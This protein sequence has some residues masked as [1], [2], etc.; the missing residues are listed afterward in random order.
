MQ[1]PDHDDSYSKP[2]TSSEE[3]A[4]GQDIADVRETFARSFGRDA[5]PL[6]EYSEQF[7]Q[8][9]LDPFDYFVEADV[10]NRETVT[11]EETIKCYER[12]FQQWK[13]S[14]EPND[15]HPACPSTRHVKEFIEWRRDTHG[16][17]RRTISGRLN[18][19]SQAYQFWQQDSALPHPEDFNP[20]ELA[21]TVTDI[22]DDEDKEFHNL[23]LEDLQEKFARIEDIKHRAVIGLQLKLG[24]RAGEVSNI[25]LQD[26]HLS[27]TDLKQQY[28]TLG[29]HPALGDHQNVLYVPHNRDGNKSS[30]PRLLPIDEELRWLLIRWL[31]IR[32]SVDDPW[33]FLSERYTQLTAKTVNNI[34]KTEFHPEYSETDDSRAIT[35][36]YGRHWFS[37]Y[38]RLEVG[39]DREHVQYMRGDR[40]Q[41]MNSFG[42]AIDEYLH[43]R[44]EYIEGI[45][46]S[47]SHTLEVHQRYIDTKTH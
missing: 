2:G 29:N 14:M 22:G 30:N 32:P 10:R 31:L 45:Y 23:S 16:N 47:Q 21:K 46:R 27:H 25:E 20:F 37:S 4:S 5:D 15:R 9:E 35:S 26:L 24:L 34:W 28:P 38:W 41:P 33:L 18:R 44:Y 43:P 1:N 6:A 8:V 40:V 19:L 13:R 17:G 39:I 3:P 7:K 11:S 12:T 36:H 42:D